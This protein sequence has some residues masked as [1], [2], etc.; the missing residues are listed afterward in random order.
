MSLHRAG[1]YPHPCLP[2]NSL[3]PEVASN[4]FPGGHDAS[5]PVIRRRL[6]HLETWKPAREWKPSETV[7]LQQKVADGQGK[8]AAQAL[9]QILSGSSPVVLTGQ[10]PGFAGGPLFVWLKALTAIQ[11]AERLSSQLDMPVRAVFWVAGD[12]AD[13]AEVR[14]LPDLPGSAP[15]DSHPGVLD[16]IRP[17]GGIPFPDPDG[18]AER[19]GRMWPGSALPAVLSAGATDLSSLMVACLRHWFGDRLVVVDAAWPE[20]RTLA[21][22]TYRTFSRSPEA[23]HKSLS[24]G[25]DAARAAGL[26]VGIRTWPDRIRLFRLGDDGGRRRV[27][28]KDGAFSDG[29]GWMVPV[30]SFP[31]ALKQ[32]GDRFSHDVVSRP[33]AAEEIF[34]VLGHVLGPGEFSYFACLGP[35]SQKIGAPLAPALARASC[36]L[37]PAGPWPAA[38]VAGWDPAERTPGAWDP[39]KMEFLLARH[40]ESNL[41]SRKWN[42]ARADYLDQ[43]GG[44]P[45]DPV[46]EAIGRKLGAFEARWRHSRLLEL[47]TRH[48]QDLSDLRRLWTLSGAGALQERVMSPWALEHHLE[49]PELLR[50]LAEVVEPGEWTHVVWEVK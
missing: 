48:R 40:P 4:L 1:F 36:T 16:G 30:R 39:M 15:L 46:I 19:L 7:R 26:P 28:V 25:M 13:L 32:E 14:Y 2:W 5:P 34:P 20:L 33:F 12:D 47:A 10:Q 17:V 11:H 50:R 35:L 21:M 42:D 37:L 29:A 43:L 3:V 23:I 38:Q 24:A 27:S 9:G 45:G 49:R 8:G 44:R 18:L 22:R 6:A 31:A 41:W